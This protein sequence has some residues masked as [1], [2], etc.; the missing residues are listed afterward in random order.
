MKY[1]HEAFR[2][3]ME[4]LGGLAKYCLLTTGTAIV[5]LPEDLPL[6]VICPASCATATIASALEN[7]QVADRVVLVTG[8][9]LLGLTASAMAS[10]RGAATIIAIDPQAERRAKALEFGATHAISPEEA[11]DLIP[12][13]TDGYGADLGIEL[14]GAA[15]V[16]QLLLA[17]QRMGGCLTLVG[18]VFPGDPVSMPMERIVRRNLTLQGIHNYAPRHLQQAVDFLTTA[19]DRFPFREV[20]RHCYPLQD[21][22]QVVAAAKMSCNVRVGVKS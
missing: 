5:R 18:A 21:I 3:G 13:V 14:S 19:R 15:T 12:P 7:H 16:F 10:M 1:G 11:P 22:K 2:L 6:E 20:V 9:G 4:L 17:S 8:A